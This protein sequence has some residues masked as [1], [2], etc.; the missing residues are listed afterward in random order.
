MGRLNFSQFSSSFR[1]NHK[2]KR[3]FGGQAGPAIIGKPDGCAMDIG[4]GRD[5]GKPQSMTR[6]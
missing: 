4:D 5:Q 3:D 2:R 6:L 1:L